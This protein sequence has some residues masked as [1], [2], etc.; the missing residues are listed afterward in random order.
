MIADEEALL[1]R[2]QLK[3]QEHF[4]LMA[5]ELLKQGADEI[6]WEEWVASVRFS[7]EEAW[8]RCNAFLLGHTLAALL[9][10][11]AP[12]PAAQPDAWVNAFV[13]AV[14]ASDSAA[15][16]VLWKS[17]PADNP[18]ADTLTRITA[19]LWLLTESLRDSRPVNDA[20]PGPFRH[21]VWLVDD[22][23]AEA[24]REALYRR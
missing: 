20:R 6:E 16:L 22:D 23:P 17:A 9:A 4:R 11:R 5:S 24:R 10:G 7:S 8:E 18:R 1:A 13:A 21:A 12:S 15:E 14:A 2:T 19:A 3:V